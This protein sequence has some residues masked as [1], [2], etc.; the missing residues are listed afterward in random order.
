M[1]AEQ[2]AKMGHSGEDLDMGTVIPADI[3]M[4]LLRQ[5]RRFTLHAAETEVDQYY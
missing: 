1:L 5:L 3:C 4:P 2:T